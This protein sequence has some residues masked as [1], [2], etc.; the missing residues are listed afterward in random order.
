MDGWA[1]L[2]A[3]AGTP[4]PVLERLAAAS[5]A[6]LQAEPVRRRYAD[7]A[8]TPGRLFLDDAQRFVREEAASLGAGGARL[9]RDCGL[10]APLARR[11][12]ERAFGATGDGAR[13]GA[14]GRLSRP[15]APRGSPYLP[16]M[17]ADAQSLHEQITESVALLRRHL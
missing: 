11:A 9:R 15:L 16:P 12:I 8:T 10:S 4:R 6:A 3:P 7:T 2:A 17:R 13:L 1:G 14:T 5:R